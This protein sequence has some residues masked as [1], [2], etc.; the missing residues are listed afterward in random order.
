MKSKFYDIHQFAVAAAYQHWDYV[1]ETN[2]DRVLASN[3]DR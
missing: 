2:A 1:D 3:L